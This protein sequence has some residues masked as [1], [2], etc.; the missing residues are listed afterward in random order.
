MRKLLACPML[1]LA[2]ACSDHLSVSPTSVDLAVGQTATIRAARI[3][4]DYRGIQWAPNRIE[5]VGD[6][7]ITVNG[8]M[9][10]S[11]QMANITVQGLAPGTGYVTTYY[12]DAHT[13]GIIRTT[14][15]TVN[16]TDCATAMKLSPE[17]TNLAGRIGEQA[18]LRVTPSIEGGHYQW[19]WGTRGD[20]RNPISFSDAPY[21]LDFTPRAN[22]SYP[23]WV[24]YITICGTAEASFAVNVGMQHRRGAGH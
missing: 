6:G 3:P 23:F 13:P 9:E 12:R 14:I 2:A 5:F 18:V 10:A 22:G 15:A 24:R 11:A 4:S 20:L 7:P 17:F 16:V 8:V 1:L 19:Y 21:F